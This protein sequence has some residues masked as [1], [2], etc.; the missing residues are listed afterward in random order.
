MSVVKKSDSTD[1]DYRIVNVWQSEFAELEGTDMFIEELRSILFVQK[2]E[3]PKERKT[4]VGLHRA[5]DM[6]DR[7]GGEALARGTV[8]VV[9][10]G[11]GRKALWMI[12]R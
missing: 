5:I 3:I 12:V 9:D 4:K 6:L 11:I 2:E 1:S 8:S 7:R 10:E